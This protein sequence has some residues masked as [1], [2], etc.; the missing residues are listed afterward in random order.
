VSERG[1]GETKLSRRPNLSRR[2]WVA[3][4]APAAP[5]GA[6]S[7]PPLVF[8]PSYFNTVLGV[9]LAAVSAIFLCARAM[10]IVIDPML[11]SAQ[12]GARG[13]RFW[14]GAALAP[15][16]VLVWLAFVAI[17]PGAG[18]L[19][20]G[21]AVL[22]LYACYS[23]SVIAHLGWAGELRPDYHGRTK[24]LA[25]WQAAS[26]AGSI[27]IL[28][29]PA[30]AGVLH[31]GGPGAGVHLMGWALIAALIV[32]VLPAIFLAPEPKPAA[33]HKS[34]LRE[35]LAA[36]VSNRALAIVLAADFAIGVAQG[37]SGSLFV[38][39][40]QSHL[41]FTNESPAL[42]LAYF[43]AALAGVPV[44]A[45]IA[46]SGAKHTTISFACF[47][48]A[49]MTMMIL[50]LPGKILGVAAIGLFF[51]G[52]ANGA[53]IFLLRAMLADVV[54]ED[55]ARVGHRR[56]GL[57]FGLLLTTSKAGAALGP[58]TFAVLALFGFDGKLGAANN[59][60][61]LGALSALFVFVP[62]L[63]YFASGWVMRAYPL[64]EA[65]QRDL[66]AQLDG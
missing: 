47:Y 19:A 64:N 11:G 39:Y 25:L 51:A 17:P 48:A 30:L 36:I 53:H 8:L 7:L 32:T 2:Q 45:R 55:E 21:A 16:C 60:S 6:L 35:A 13:R 12:D 33:A 54:D 18:A 50:V 37:V 56:S 66:R 63:L 65:R 49:A 40:F 23:A 34:T 26:A 14:L 27:L 22:A 4:I 43:L 42:L 57:M 10:D 62:A 29:L 9:E 44:W 3:F 15:L 41:G 38:F 28:F 1:A 5:L 46:K 20:I 31:W 58:L 24:V 59:A 61:A 52:F